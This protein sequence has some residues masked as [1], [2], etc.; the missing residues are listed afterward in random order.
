MFETLFKF[1]CENVNINKKEEMLERQ[2]R[3]EKEEQGSKERKSAESCRG[4]GFGC[5]LFLSIFSQSW[6]D[7]YLQIIAT[8]KIKRNTFYLY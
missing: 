7:V 8:E 1:E 5:L 2:G 6:K 3:R 4:F